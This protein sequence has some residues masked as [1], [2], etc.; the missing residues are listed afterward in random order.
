MAKRKQTKKVEMK[1][2][3][4]PEVASVSFIKDF[5]GMLNSQKFN[6]KKGDALEVSPLIAEWLKKHGVIE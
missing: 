3:P 1:E 4:K 6:A 5:N 2:A